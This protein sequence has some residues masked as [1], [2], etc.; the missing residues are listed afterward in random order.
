MVICKLRHCSGVW[1]GVWG[2]VRGEGKRIVEAAGSSGLGEGFGSIFM[3]LHGYGAGGIAP[4][5][6]G[7]LLSP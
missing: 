6:Y 4:V 5:R 2:G 1:D 3:E 7:R